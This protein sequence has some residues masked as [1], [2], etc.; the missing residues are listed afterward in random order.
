MERPPRHVLV[1]AAL[2]GRF[3]NVVARFLDGKWG[4]LP[5]VWDVPFEE[6]V[7]EGVRRGMDTFISARP[8]GEGYW[9]SKTERGFAVQYFERGINNDMTEFKELELAFRHLIRCQ[10]DMLQLKAE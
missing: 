4:L 1:D 9:L 8:H 10:L 7:Q 6:V 2:T 5:S 3:H